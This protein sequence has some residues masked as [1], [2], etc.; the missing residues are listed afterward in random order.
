L[1][2][3]RSASNNV[4]R[5]PNS[6]AGTIQL[7]LLRDRLR[8]LSSF[9]RGRA[10]RRFGGFFHWKAEL[11]TKSAQL[12]PYACRPLNPLIIRKILTASETEILLKIQDQNFKKI[13]NA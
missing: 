11:S 6:N 10:T 12:L 9:F 2:F 5:T 8:A 13:G 7:V 3:E 4:P 1:G